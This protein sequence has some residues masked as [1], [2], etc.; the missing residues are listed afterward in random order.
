MVPKENVPYLKYLIPCQH[1][2]TNHFNS[3]V[4]CDPSGLHVKKP[5][6]RENGNLKFSLKGNLT[7]MPHLK[8]QLHLLTHAKL[9]TE[10]KALTV[11]TPDSLTTLRL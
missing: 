7:L 11:H 3:S 4:K 9:T 5:S 6:P 8:N 2:Q 1:T 10:Q